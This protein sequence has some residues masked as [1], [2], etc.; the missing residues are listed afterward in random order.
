MLLYKALLTNYPDPDPDVDVINCLLQWAKCDEDVVFSV[1]GIRFLASAVPSRLYH[2]SVTGVG[3]MD[4]AAVIYSPAIHID[5]NVH[6]LERVTVSDNLADGVLIMRNDVYAGAR[7]AS[8][9]VRDNGGTG[10]TVH[11]SFFELYDCLLSGNRRA[12]FEYNPSYTADEALQIR[13]GIRHAVVFNHSRSI[14]L[15]NE[16]RVWVTTPRRFVN[17]T[18]TYDLEVSANRLYKVVVDVIDY[19]PETNVELVT[20]YD[21]RRQSIRPDTLHWTI[22]EDMVDFPVV[23]QLT[24]LTIRWRMSGISSG[25][26]AFVLRSSEFRRFII[27]IFVIL[28]GGVTLARL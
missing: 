16:N 2:V 25:R 8:S 22:D 18:W 20:V 19:N 26:L 13:A 14:H 12:G 27:Y 21:S 9:T 10:V 15:E 4:P 6:T 28:Q 5:Y 3:L 24:Y 1:V 11:G 23:S 17:E 7:L